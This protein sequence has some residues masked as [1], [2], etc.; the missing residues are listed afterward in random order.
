MPHILKFIVIVDGFI[1][2]TFE[3]YTVEMLTSLKQLRTWSVMHLYTE[4][5]VRDN[6]FKARY[7]YSATPI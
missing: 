7:V 6:S 5:E 2:F 1:D 4:E 3:S